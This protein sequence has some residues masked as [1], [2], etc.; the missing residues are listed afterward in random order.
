MPRSYEDSTKED[1]N[2]MI[3]ALRDL[4]KLQ[5]VRTGDRAMAL[6]LPF[7]FKE[8]GLVCDVFKAQG[9]WVAQAC[10]GWEALR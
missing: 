6:S 4:K 10:L 9:Y 8:S 1:F 2:R 7:R 5:I 3:G